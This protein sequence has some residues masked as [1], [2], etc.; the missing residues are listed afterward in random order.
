MSE[1]NEYD[2]IAKLKKNIP[3]ICYYQP[4]YNLV[5][6][7]SDRTLLFNHS[8]KKE[9]SK[10]FLMQKLWKSYEVNSAYRMVNLKSFV[11]ENNIKK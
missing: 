5:H 6:K 10:K 11:E 4:K 7:N 1:R 9:K 2:L 8:N 3:S